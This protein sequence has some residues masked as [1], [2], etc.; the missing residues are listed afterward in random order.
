MRTLTE[1]LME[2]EARQSSDLCYKTASS[3]LFGAEMSSGFGS[4]RSIGSAGSGFSIGNAPNSVTENSSDFGFRYRADKHEDY[5][6]D[7]INL[8]ILNPIDPNKTLQKIH[9]N[10]KK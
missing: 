5:G 8:D 7:H 9:I 3:Y 2:E 4:A 10:W 1:T 6:R